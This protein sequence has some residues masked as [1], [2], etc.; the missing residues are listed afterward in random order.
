MTRRIRVAS[1]G[2]PS[3]TLFNYE[4]TRM[5]A[6]AIATDEWIMDIFTGLC[7][8]IKHS[9]ELVY[10]IFGW[11]RGVSGTCCDVFDEASK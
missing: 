6:M 2:R 8:G 1:D 5:F 3:L 10:G 9:S 11:G 4:R 7:H